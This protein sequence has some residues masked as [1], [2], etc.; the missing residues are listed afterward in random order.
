LPRLAKFGL[1]EC[2]NCILVSDALGAIKPDPAAFRELLKHGCDPNRVL[3]VDDQLANVESARCLGLT[4]IHAQESL[5]WLRVI[6]RLLDIETAAAR[7]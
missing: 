3:F 4:A 1:L 6:D 5:G 2:F 7:V